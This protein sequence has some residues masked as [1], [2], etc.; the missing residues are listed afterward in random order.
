MMTC[1]SQTAYRILPTAYRH[2][3]GGGKDRR[4]ARGRQDPRTGWQLGPHGDHDLPQLTL[5]TM[6]FVRRSLGG[7]YDNFNQGNGLHKL[8]IV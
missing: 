3:R 7:S 1:E 6:T 5:T 2:R 8:A 4:G